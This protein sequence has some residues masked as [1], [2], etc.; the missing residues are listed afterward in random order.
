MSSQSLSSLRSALETLSTELSASP[1]RSSLCA[2]Q[3]RDMLRMRERDLS[4]AVGLAKLFISKD[5]E[6]DREMQQMAIDKDDLASIVATL[7][8]E[9]A[10]LHVRMT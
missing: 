1:S 2:E 7:K 8:Q 6:R 9:N 4:A 5:E 10:I 3:L